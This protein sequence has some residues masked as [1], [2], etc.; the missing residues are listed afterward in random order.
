MVALALSTF[1][2]D[3]KKIDEINQIKEGLLE[4]S[5]ILARVQ[6]ATETATENVLPFSSPTPAVRI[7][8]APEA[9]ETT[10]PNKKAR[11]TPSKSRPGF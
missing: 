11:T 7:R 6:K 1:A 8:K 5:G 10:I 3:P 4:E 2:K 9:T